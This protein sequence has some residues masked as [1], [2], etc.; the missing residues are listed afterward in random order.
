MSQTDA[1]EARMLS[2]TALRHDLRFARRML[3]KSPLFTG[4]VVLTLALGIGLN[5]AVFSLIDTL[6]LQIG[7]AHV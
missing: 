4:I 3:V 6:L 7:R 5:T 2:L 1:H